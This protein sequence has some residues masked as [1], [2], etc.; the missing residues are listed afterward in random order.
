[1]ARKDPKTYVVERAE[2]RAALS[3]PVRLELLGHFMTPGGMSIGEIAARMGRPA[4]SLYYHFRLLERVGLIKRVGTRRRA[5]RTE[6]LYEPV[7]PRIALSAESSSESALRS[8]LKTMSI[9][10]RMAERDLEAALR[11]GTCRPHGAHRNIFASRMHC[12]LTRDTL[13]EL[14]GHLSAIERILA[15]EARRRKLQPDADQYCSVTLAL[16]PL[17][18]RG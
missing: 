1:M 2:E 16:L 3:S 9:A 11:S 17:R 12:R 18:G 14:N 4:S 13:A 7:A 10:F 6:A 5:K 8:A 15:R